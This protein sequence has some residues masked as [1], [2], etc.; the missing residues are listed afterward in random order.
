VRAQGGC[1]KSADRPALLLVPPAE[2]G[3]SGGG[4]EHNHDSTPNN[5]SFSE[6]AADER[7]LCQ[8]CIAVVAA[9]GTA[10]PVINNAHVTF[11]QDTPA[12]GG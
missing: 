5:E 3:F 2:Q 6:R 9:P 7:Q 4:R 11:C 8:P 1:C 10:R 12:V